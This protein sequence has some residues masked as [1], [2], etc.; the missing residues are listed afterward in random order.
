MMNDYE[1]PCSFDLFNKKNFTNFKIYSFIISLHTYIQDQEKRT[2]LFLPFLHSFDMTKRNIIWLL[3]YYTIPNIFNNLSHFLLLISRIY[4]I[5]SIEKIYYH[6]ILC[7]YNY[8]WDQIH[9]HHKN[10]TET[11]YGKN[12]STSHE[13]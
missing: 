13:V 10:P 12:W 5:V 3:Q 1:F 2:N 6:D 8:Y 11:V 7:H 4:Q 9:P